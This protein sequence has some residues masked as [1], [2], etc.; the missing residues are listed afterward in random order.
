MLYANQTAF[1]GGRMWLIVLVTGFLVLS[2]GT[3][4]SGTHAGSELLERGQRPHA[5]REFCTCGRAT[6]LA[7][8]QHHS[9]HSLE[10][11]VARPIDPTYWP[12]GSG[13]LCGLRARRERAAYQH[14]GCGRH[15][16][17]LPTGVVS[18]EPGEGAE[19]RGIASAAACPFAETRN[20]GAGGERTE[21]KMKWHRTLTVTPCL[22]S[23]DL[24]EF[25]S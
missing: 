2:G 6:D 9:H 3:L 22:G 18:D 8:T 24:L 25:R 16:A 11:E 13:F 21:R 12:D 20:A 10:L 4:T 14:F 5:Q 7:E 1:H 19:D 15:C 17:D 23:Q